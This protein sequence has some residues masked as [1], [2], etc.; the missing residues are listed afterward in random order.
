MAVFRVANWQFSYEV[1]GEGFPL[2]L[3]PDL[4]GCASSWS[5]YTALLGELCRTIAY[6][7]REVSLPPAVTFAAFSSTQIASQLE[8]FLATLAIEHCYLASPPSSWFAALEFVTQHPG[9]IEG[10]LLVAPAL[11][12]DDALPAF[13][14]A[15]FVGHP[16]PPVP[17]LLVVHE[18]TPALPAFLETLLGS[19]PSCFRTVLPAQASGHVGH[20]MIH[21]LM[22]RERQRNLVRGASFLL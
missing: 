12:P 3:M 18:S 21:F 13:L 17:T 15:Q 14:P 20:A 6:E 19:L 11:I 8:M 22:H 1:E 2:V 7:V 9:H 5:S 10:L 16:V 4:P